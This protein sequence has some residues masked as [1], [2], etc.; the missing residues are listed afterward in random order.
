MDSAHGGTSG[1]G[2]GRGRSTRLLGWGFPAWSL[3]GTPSP[4]RSIFPSSAPA[5]H[6]APW[7]CQAS[8]RSREDRRSPGVLHPDDGQWLPWV[9]SLSPRRGGVRKRLS[10]RDSDRGCHLESGHLGAASDG[11]SLGEGWRGQEWDGNRWEE[12]AG[13]RGAGSCAQSRRRCPVGSVLGTEHPPQW[14][15]YTS[16]KL[17]L[18]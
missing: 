18:F 10:A 15:C 3:P 16:E 17:F 1:C 13:G 12:D 9:L 11:S 4:A 6:G 7:F 5:P 14:H 2:F 8:W